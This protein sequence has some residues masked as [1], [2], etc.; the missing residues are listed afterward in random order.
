MK[1]LNRHTS[2]DGP[3]IA[4]VHVHDSAD[5]T[6]LRSAPETRRAQSHFDAIYQPALDPY[7]TRGRWY[8]RRKRLVLLAS[9]PRRRFRQG[10][11]PACGSGELTRTLAM[12]CERLI[13]S[14]FCTA[15][16]TQAYLRAGALP[17]VVLQTHCIPDEWPTG[18]GQF[19]LIVISEVCSFLTKGDVDELVNRCARSLA[20]DG[21]VAVCD[22]RHPF[23][24]RV[25]SAEVAHHAF[26]CRPFAPLVRHAEEDFLLS[27][28]SPDP[29]SVARREGIV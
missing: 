5:P 20:P 14:D 16:I 27:L 12:R 13:A 8:E 3:V 7:G 15:A 19:D 23:G 9:L 10:F 21:V 22:W 25:L 6:E 18:E 29:R 4:T 1:R 17:N 11:E 28:W 26:D 24:A 2:P